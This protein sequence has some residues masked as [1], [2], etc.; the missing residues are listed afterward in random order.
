[1]IEIVYLV[2]TSDV[3]L[4]FCIY[5]GSKFHTIFTTSIICKINP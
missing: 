5:I 2:F 1:M 3:R 4:I